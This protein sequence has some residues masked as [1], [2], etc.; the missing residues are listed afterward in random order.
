MQNPLNNSPEIN[1]QG[2]A[3]VEHRVHNIAEYLINDISSGIPGLMDGDAGIAL[4][5][6][7]Y[8][9]YSER[10]KWA[11]K[12]FTFLE[13][14][15]E[16]I[17]RGFSYPSF[18][19]GLAGICWTVD[20][21]VKYDFLA[22]SLVG[23]L[24]AVDNYLLDRMLRYGELNLFDFF[25]GAGGIA[26]YFLSKN[27]IS[28]EQRSALGRFVT[29]IARNAI[30][31]DD[32]AVC[33][34]YPVQKGDIPGSINMGMAHG[35]PGLIRLLIRFCQREIQPEIAKK[36]IAGACKYLVK[37]VIKSG[38]SVSLFPA[39]VADTG[40]VKPSRLA[41][42]YGDLG[43]GYA[44]ETAGIIL[45]TKEFKDFGMKVL[46]HT[47]GRTSP[48]CNGIK[49]PFFCHGAAGV[50]YM[51][52]RIYMISGDSRFKDAALYWIDVLFH[53]PVIINGRNGRCN[54]IPNNI[55]LLNGW[56]GI[57]LVLISMCSGQL[58][59]WD[60]MFLMS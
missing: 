22:K 13:Y 26:L 56:S 23:D 20:H 27:N 9:R 18:A 57:G 47:L 12:G 39:H 4:F 35:L 43:I 60:E 33:W 44:L 40:P 36:L 3:S 19:G 15:F 55:S 59:C 29:I 51:Y 2:L 53:H 45:E 16:E 30:Y 48:V 37:N 28:S 31:D 21:L 54:P 42:C 58:S 7:Y 11:D 24:S 32:G 10:K 41:W 46:L 6:Y 8:S 49:G 1:I 5:S 25:H 38:D 34:K 52:H 17:N 14:L 50:A